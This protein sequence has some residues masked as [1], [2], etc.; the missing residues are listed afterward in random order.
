MLSYWLNGGI[1]I[2][3]RIMTGC[4]LL[5]H[6]DPET[7]K[8]ADMKNN[9]LK[10]IPC[11]VMAFA[12]VSANAADEDSGFRVRPYIGADAG[13]AFTDM[14]YIH[15]SH[16]RDHYH[17]VDDGSAFVVNPHLGVEFDH[18]SGFGFK[19]EAEGFFLDNED[20]DV[21]VWDSYG[22]YHDTMTV[23]SSGMFVNL[24]GNYRINH[25]LVP[26]VGTGM[27]FARNKSSISGFSEHNT[28]F[29]FNVKTGT[30]IMVTDNFGFDLGLR[31][32]DY[33]KVSKH[34]FEEDLELDSFDI[35]A[36]VNLKF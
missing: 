35:Y 33:G 28:E 4:C 23:K 7:F 2:S 20:Y 22:R 8:R 27:G 13:V 24:I 16:H 18:S 5:T 29:A 25:L 6:D 10:L 31:Y 19:V 36:G 12:G 21:D 26:Y 32:V 1:I 15:H 14:N 11:A 17:D 3:V 34:Y 30:E 9:L